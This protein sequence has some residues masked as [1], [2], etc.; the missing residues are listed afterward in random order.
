MKR[1]YTKR[2]IPPIDDEHSSNLFDY[3]ASSHLSTMQQ[4]QRDEQKKKYLPPIYGVKMLEIIILINYYLFIY[5]N[6]GVYHVM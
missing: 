3:Y 4:Q 5:L 1:A 2:S 6:L